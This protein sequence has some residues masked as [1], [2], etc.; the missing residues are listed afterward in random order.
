MKKFLGIDRTPSLLERPL[1]AA[2]K[3]NSDLPADLEMESIP[4]MEHLSL[5][6]A[7]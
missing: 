3:L 2:S 4:P 6:D 7:H 5:V 1:S